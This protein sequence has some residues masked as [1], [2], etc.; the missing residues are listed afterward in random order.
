MDDIAENVGRAMLNVVSE[1]FSQSYGS[2]GK[3]WAPLKLRHGKIMVDSGQ[4]AASYKIV[5]ETRKVVKIASDLARA[6]WLERGFTATA[7][8]A[9]AL[10]LG[11]SGLF[12][13]SVTVPGRPVLPQG[14]ATGEWAKA[15]KRAVE[16]G[17]KN[18]HS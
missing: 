12:R 1:E 15:I 5:S 14:R 6:A 16:E 2:D 10:M 17:L 11:D 3:S 7:I 9:Q 18:G 4:L 8:D 13:K